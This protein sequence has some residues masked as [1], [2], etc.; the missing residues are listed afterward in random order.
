VTRKSREQFLED[1]V[2]TGKAD[3]F[4]RYALALE[5][6]KLGR[7]E[8]SIAAFH[9]LRTFDPRYVPMYLMAAQLL[10]EVGKRDD[11]TEWL[12]AGISVAKEQRDAKASS[13]LSNLLA[14]LESHA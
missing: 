3:S 4:A 14:E 7:S 8:D 12:N 10:V 5:Y 6:K 1:L 2:H 11:A 13:E 9:A